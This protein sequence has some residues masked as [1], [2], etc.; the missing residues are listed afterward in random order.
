MEPG[1]SSNGDETM[2]FATTRLATC[3]KY[4]DRA[5]LSREWPRADMTIG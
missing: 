3:F 4:N 5:A 2:P 1:L